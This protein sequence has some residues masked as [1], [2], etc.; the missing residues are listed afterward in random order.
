MV[1]VPLRDNPL[2]VPLDGVA[3]ILATG[4]ALPA[5][6][7]NAN[8]ALLVA[9]PPSSTSSVD[10]LG[11]NSPK[12]SFSVNFDAPDPACAMVILP[13]PFEMVI[14]VPAVKVAFVNVLPL[15]FPINNCPSL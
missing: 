12:P 2:V 5:F 10:I 6:P 1:P 13:L 15:E 11:Y 14:P 3:A 9:V 7:V 4:V 8:F